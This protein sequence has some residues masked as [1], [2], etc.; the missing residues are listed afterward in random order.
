M[1]NIELNSVRNALMLATLCGGTRQIMSYLRDRFEKLTS[2]KESKL[3]LIEE[4]YF[5]FIMICF[6]VSFLFA[7]FSAVVCLYNSKVGNIF[8]AISGALFLLALL[9]PGPLLLLCSRS[10]EPYF[11]PRKPAHKKSK[12]P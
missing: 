10:K 6:Y 9:L 4:Q 5:R 8:F 12:K 2:G 1:T 3:E 11:G 7:I